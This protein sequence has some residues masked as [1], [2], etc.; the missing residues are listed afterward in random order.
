MKVRHIRSAIRHSL[1]QRTKRKPRRNHELSQTGICQEEFWQTTKVLGECPSDRWGG[2]NILA[3]HISCMLT[4]KQRIAW[5]WSGAALLYVEQGVLFCV[6]INEIS[7]LLRPLGAKCAAQCQSGGHRFSNRTMT[8]TLSCSEVTF[9]ELWSK[10]PSNL[11]QLEDQSRVSL[12]VQG[13]GPF[14]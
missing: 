8:Q 14:F 2:W 1:S 10:E 6:G 13:P 3:G 4:C 5:L 9:D 12:R 11:R 7:R